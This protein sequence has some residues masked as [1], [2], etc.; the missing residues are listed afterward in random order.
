M[1]L[2]SSKFHIREAEELK[3]LKY[4]QDILESKYNI[5]TESQ[6]QF[7]MQ[8]LNT[9]IAQ[10]NESTTKTKHI[11]YWLRISILVLSASATIILGLN[12]ISTWIMLLPKITLF[13]ISSDIALIITTII[14]LLSSLAAFWDIETYWIRLKIMLNKLKRLRYEFVFTVMGDKLMTNEKLNKYLE[15]FI[16]FQ[17]DEYWENY[18]DSIEKD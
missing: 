16:S 6:K 1:A 13:E 3:L 12:K 17:A 11:Y 9:K 2:E 5:S 15:K 4:Y 7:M 8:L 14:T 10:L 18:F